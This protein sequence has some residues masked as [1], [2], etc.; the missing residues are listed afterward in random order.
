[1][2]WRRARDGRQPR[3]QCSAVGGRTHEER[4]VRYR[5]SWSR[6][7][8]TSKAHP[9]LGSLCGGFIST[10]RGARRKKR[11]ELYRVD[12]QGAAHDPQPVFVNADLVRYIRKVR[13]GLDHTMVAF[14]PDHRLEVQ[15]RV[16]DVIARLR[17]AKSLSG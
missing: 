10:V 5:A 17:E 14:D 4:L 13:G 8:S 9:N 6:A 7:P 12:T 15:E 16:G 1:M 3:N 2:R 11:A